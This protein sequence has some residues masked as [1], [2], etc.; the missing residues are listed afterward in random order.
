MLYG[1]WAVVQRLVNES[2]G[3]TLESLISGID[4]QRAFVGEQSLLEILQKIVH[5]G[6]IL[7]R[8]GDHPD[9]LLVVLGTECSQNITLDPCSALVFSCDK[10]LQIR[11]QSII[12]LAADIRVVC[13]SFI[14]VAPKHEVQGDH[15]EGLIV[16]LLGHQKA[17][18][19]LAVHNIGGFEAEETAFVMHVAA[20][21]LIDFFQ[22]SAVEFGILLTKEG[23]VV[24]EAF[25][26]IAEEGSAQSSGD[27]QGSAKHPRMV[28][29][30]GD[31]QQFDIQRVESLILLGPA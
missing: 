4:G 6:I 12:K 3:V 26:G 21:P 14:A 11:L 20:A 29:I 17:I 23:E 5:S 25:F 24:C 30:G 8:K 18:D 27:G 19:G 15:Q 7:G 9:G 22:E 1:R 13:L 2:G 16:S 31:A 10:A 28:A